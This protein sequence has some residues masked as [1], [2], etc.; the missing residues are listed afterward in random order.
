MK[1][2]ILISL[3]ILSIGFSQND[4]NLIAGIA[5]SRVI[6][7]DMNDDNNLDIENSSTN[8]SM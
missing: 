4:L 3:T 6:G 2:I 7:D 8:L 5:Y 1:Q